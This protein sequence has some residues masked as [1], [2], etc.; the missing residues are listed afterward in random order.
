MYTSKNEMYR[1]SVTLLPLLGMFV[2]K[3]LVLPKDHVRLH[4]F[5]GVYWGILDVL[6]Y[7]GPVFEALSHIVVSA[8]ALNEMSSHRGEELA[9]SHLPL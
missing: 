8:L 2:L 3:H 1:E 7:A 5:D 9:L 4:A 6:V